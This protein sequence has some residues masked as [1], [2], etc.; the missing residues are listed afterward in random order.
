[1]F[2]RTLDTFSLFLVVW[3]LNRDHSS[4]HEDI[5]TIMTKVEIV[6]IAIQ[7][8]DMVVTLWP[9]CKVRLCYTHIDAKDYGFTL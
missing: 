8:I 2:E 5:G 1:M 3:K 9:V 4:T 6:S 7:L